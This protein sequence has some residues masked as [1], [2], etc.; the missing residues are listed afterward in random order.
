MIKK[1]FIDSDVI[2]DVATGRIPFVENSKTSLSLIERGFALGVMSS[3]SVTNIYYVLRKLSSNE[4]AKYFLNTIIKY[5]SIV[6][7]DHENIT[8]A[9]ES[10]FLDFEDGVQNYCALK[11]QCDLILTRNIDDYKFSELHVLEPIEF[12]ALYK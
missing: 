8:R 11:N 10:K 5:I 12:I 7:V 4:K 1:V 2:L 6:T 9:L 3:N